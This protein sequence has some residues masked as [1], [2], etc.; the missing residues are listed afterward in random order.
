[1]SIEIINN[2]ESL[3]INQ[4]V[5]LDIEAN[6]ARYRYKKKEFRKIL[7]IQPPN[8]DKKIFDPQMARDKKYENFPPYGLAVL[9]AN[10]KKDY[11]CKIL[12][13]NDV[14]I[15]AACKN[16]D[17]NFDYD[18]SV[19]NSI[20][21]L[22]EEFKPDLI[23][24][25]CMFSQT[26]KSLINVA[27]YIKKNYGLPICA[28]GVHISNSFSNLKTRND[29]VKDLSEIDFLFLLEAEIAFKNFLDFLNNKIEID[30]LSQIFF[31]FEK[32]KYYFLKTTRPNID[33]VNIIPDFSLLNIKKTSN[34]GRIGAYK[35]LLDP[36]K[37]VFATSISN[38]GCRGQCTFC[39]V[40]NF[41]GK[42]VRGRC[43][44][45]VIDELKILKF[46]HGVNHIMWLDDDLL[47]NEKRS[48]EL[49]NRMTQEN[50]DMTWDASNGLV[51]KSCTFEVLKAAAESGCIG[52][53]IGMESGNPKVLRDIVKPGTV[54]NFLDAAENLRKIPEINAGVYIMIGFPGETYQMILDTIEV[55]LQ[56][57]LDWYTINPLTPLPNTP[58][59]DEMFEAG[60]IE[61]ADFQKTSF[62]NGSFGSLKKRDFL[63]K[64]FR[65]AFDKDKDSIPSKQEIDD[66]WAYMTF[67]LNFVRLLEE[68]RT[69]KLDQQFKWLKYISEVVTPD[70]VFAKYFLGYLYYK[71]G[72][73]IPKKLISD[74]K[75]ILSTNTYWRERFNNFEL[76]VD[77]LKN[78]DFSQISTLVSERKMLK[79]KARSKDILR[80]IHK[81]KKLEIATL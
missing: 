24:L 15:D 40:R 48:I 2:F 6:L 39:S 66:I 81:K 11:E 30:Q 22:I 8:G 25:T 13:L 7:L 59:F 53:R 49:F 63:S 4:D 64:D 52:V 71:S 51:A 5:I 21:S 27:E 58:V 29:F 68:D 69:I 67:H 33:E 74:T 60:M 47:Y 18:S 12:N 23:A 50:L 9:A 43:V 77:H 16:N 70:N 34:N 57:D 46:E 3:K 37:T 78:V 42:G 62:I 65:K 19:T 44:E 76:S 28:G 54:K 14:V 79:N 55:C 73:D 32:K 38:R 26:H 45:S 41:N 56:M 75:K 80:N 17:L 1:M 20:N 36:D 31:N 72:E 35:F 61:G 10:L